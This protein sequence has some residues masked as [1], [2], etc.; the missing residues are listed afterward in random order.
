M[1]GQQ[2]LQQG[3]AEVSLE[4]KTEL[5][6]KEERKLGTGDEADAIKIG[7]KLFGQS[8]SHYRDISFVCWFVSITMALAC[9]TLLGGFNAA[10]SIVWC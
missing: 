1:A 5:S 6:M 9:K 10:A 7:K 3:M 4:E 8:I 2:Q